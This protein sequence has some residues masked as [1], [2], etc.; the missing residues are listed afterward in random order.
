MEK[1][2]PLPGIRKRA[3]WIIFLSVVLP[4]TSP[5]IWTYAFVSVSEKSEVGAVASDP[6]S[7]SYL[8][9]FPL[10]GISSIPNRASSTRT[11]L[12]RVSQVPWC[13][14]IS[15]RAKHSQFLSPALWMLPT[16]PV[17][18][19]ALICLLPTLCLF[20]STCDSWLLSVSFPSLLDSDRASFPLLVLSHPLFSAL[21]NSQPILCLLLLHLTG[22]YKAA[23]RI[24]SEA[25]PWDTSK[26][27][28]WIYR[29]GI[30]QVS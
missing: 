7:Q 27:G 10:A 22:E 30:R 17:S 9:S 3:P 13:P 11:L 21:S 5:S 19:F 20:F 18:R 25:R 2:L 28:L 12:G 4:A 1:C 26:G 6:K 14:L 29:C 24:G 8:L 15:V 23:T 16:G